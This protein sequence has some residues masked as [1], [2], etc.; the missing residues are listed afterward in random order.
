MRCWDFS[1]AP[2]PISKTRHLDQQLVNLHNTTS[3]WKKESS[4]SIM[5]LQWPMW[6]S[7]QEPAALLQVTWLLSCPEWP[8]SIQPT[9]PILLGAFCTFIKCYETTV[10][11]TMRN[12]HQKSLALQ[13]RL[14]PVFREYHRA[15][16]KR[17]LQ[18][19]PDHLGSSEKQTGIGA[20]TA[21]HVPAQL[22]T[23]LMVFNSLA[24]CCKA[25]MHGNQHCSVSV[26]CTSAVKVGISHKA[27]LVTW[28]TRSLMQN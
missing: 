8:P 6:K 7:E 15:V 13:H 14:Q 17:V 24:V 5:W 1:G 25:H 22:R 20:Q 11:E 9:S 4:S 16:G 2:E 27:E 18:S 19:L 21:L 23:L 28:P 10:H 3:G 12:T 26:C